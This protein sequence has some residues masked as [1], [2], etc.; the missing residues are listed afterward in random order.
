[1][2]NNQKD[3]NH[4]KK[5]TLPTNTNRICLEGT[6]SPCRD[7]VFTGV[8]SSDESE[9]GWTL[10]N[11]RQDSHTVESHTWLGP[12]G[13]TAELA[14]C[15]GTAMRVSQADTIGKPLAQ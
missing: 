9:T 15:G 11:R 4:H 7:P 12:P 3:L 10:V 13:S 5:Q 8:F 2:L 6:Q 14:L 1:M